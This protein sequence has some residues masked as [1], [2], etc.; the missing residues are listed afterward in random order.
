MKIYTQLTKVNKPYLDIVFSEGLKCRYNTEANGIWFS[1]ERKFYNMMHTFCFSLPYTDNTMR[2]G[3]FNRYDWE[4]NASV[5][6]AVKDIPTEYLTLEEGALYAYK[7]HNSDSWGYL[8]ECN[9]ESDEKFAQPDN[10]MKFDKST[11][12]IIFRDIYEYL[13]GYPPDESKYSDIPNVSFDN[14]LFNDKW[15]F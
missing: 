15:L 3:G 10:V 13:F 1:R 14:F 8:F 2:I 9:T 5:L 7:Y 6:I 12:F 4:N 11:D